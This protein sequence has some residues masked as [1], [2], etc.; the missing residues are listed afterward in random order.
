MWRRRRASFH[1]RAGA[2]L[3]DECHPVTCV[4]RPIVLCCSK[5]RGG[6]EMTHVL[7]VDRN[8]SGS[9]NDRNPYLHGLFAPIADEVTVLAPKVIGEIPADLHGVY[10]RNGPNP[11][12]KPTDLH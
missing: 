5:R 2:T 7:D 3:G 6:N 4:N 12:H 1:G 11:S 9:L 8:S 10:V